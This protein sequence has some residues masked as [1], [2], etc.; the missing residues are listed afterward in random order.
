M[1]VLFL[2]HDEVVSLLPME[3]CIPLMRDSLVS[4]AEGLVHQPLRTIVRP[5]DAAGVMGLMPSYSSGAHSAFGLKAICVFPGNA[6]QG[7]DSH[8]GAVLLFSAESGE[9]LAVINASAVTAVRTAAISGVATR[10]LARE[11]A[12]D[13]CVIGAGVQARSHIEAM[14]HVRQIRRCRVASRRVENARKL[15]G[16]LR[17]SYAF[18][19]EAVGTLEAAL[20]GA[21]LIVTATNSAEAFVRREWVSEGAHLNAVGSCTPN[22]RELDAA[23][24]AASS[25]FVDSVESAVNEAGDYLRAAREGVVGPGHIRAE[26]GEVLRGT[27]PGRTSA[28]EITLFK[29]LGLAVEDL[30]AARYLYDKS[31]ETGAGTWV[32]F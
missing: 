8:Q 3:E 4:L 7:K 12:G 27:K 30:A 2:S 13:L 15:A 25:L 5:P 10:A 28:D 17:E 19:I 29:S 20:R 31:K 26:L 21:D 14:S 22:T 18:P 16:E 9:L 6:A 24:V 32:R 23:T 1:N 11:D